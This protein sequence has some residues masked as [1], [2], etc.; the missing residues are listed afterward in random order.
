MDTRHTHTYT[1]TEEKHEKND[2]SA[3]KV[4]KN[5]TDGNQLWWDEEYWECG[6][7]LH[8]SEQMEMEEHRLFCLS[9]RLNLGFC[10]GN[11]RVYTYFT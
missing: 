5:I 6:Q 9:T 8:N 11:K 7:A 2:S 1:L 3:E 4:L 10:I